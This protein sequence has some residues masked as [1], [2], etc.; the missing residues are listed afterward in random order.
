MSHNGLIHAHVRFSPVNSRHECLQGFT[1]SLGCN[2]PLHVAI[3]DPPYRLIGKCKE[4]HVRILQRG[5]ATDLISKASLQSRP[6]RR[7]TNLVHGV[8]HALVRFDQQKKRKSPGKIVHI[9]SA[10]AHSGPTMRA[11][12]RMRRF[13]VHRGPPAPFES[14]IKVRA[15]CSHRMFR[16]APAAVRRTCGRSTRTLSTSSGKTDR[17]FGS[18]RQIEYVLRRGC[19]RPRHAHHVACWRD[20]HLGVGW[21]RAARD[22]GRDTTPLVASA[23]ITGATFGFAAKDIIG[24]FMSG[25]LT[26]ANDRVKR[27]AEITA[28]GHRGKVVKIDMSRLMLRTDQGDTVLIPSANYS[29]QQS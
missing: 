24:N 6:I 10:H 2:A 26:V 1:K 16:C 9:G 13:A 22:R 29:G 18:F 17:S 15:T 19:R 23:G 7:A 21:A 20:C 14:L 28:A 3:H 27:G 4:L 25:V 11:C 12:L 5:W 8:T